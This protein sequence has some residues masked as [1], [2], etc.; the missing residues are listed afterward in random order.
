VCL[1]ISGPELT[2]LSFCDLPGAYFARYSAVPSLRRRLCSQR[3]D[4]QRQSR[5]KLL[6][7]RIGQ[8]P[9]D[10]IRFQTE[11]FDPAHRHMRK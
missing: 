11:L 2:D 9:R 1:E 6:G 5:R 4:C 8:G 3:V 10:H 7:H